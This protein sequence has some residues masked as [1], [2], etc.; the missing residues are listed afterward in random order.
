MRGRF[1]WLA[2]VTALLAQSAVAT[3]CERPAW[4]QWQRFSATAIQAD[5]RVLESS[6][7]ANHSTS[8][9]Q[10]YA[11]FFAL[12]ANEPATFERIWQWSKNNLAQGDLGQHLPAWLWGQGPDGRWAVQDANAASDADLWFAYSLLEAARLWQRPN[13]AADAR[14]LLARVR[15]DEVVELPGLGPTLLPGPKGFVLPEHLWRLNLSYLPPF[16]L[17]RL[18]LEE[19]K[20]PWTALLRQLPTLLQGAGPHQLAPDWTGY[21]GTAP[22]RG[23]V[24]DD[25]LGPTQGS[26]DAIRVY[27]W[28]GLTDAADPLSK[29]LLAALEGMTQATADLGVPPEKVDVRSGA[30]AGQGPVGFSAALVPFL[31]QQGHT[32]LADAQQRRAEAGLGADQPLHYYDQMLGLF[33]LGWGAGHYRFAAD[34]RLQPSWKTPCTS[35]SP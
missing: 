31:R 4:P 8:E 13:Y 26:Y 33:G 18:A 29:P 9:G 5:G 19:P 28:A 20:G 23:L 25:P 6:L 24:V 21:R 22:A 15:A 3:T 27:L 16:L 17:R 2:L 35:T 7:K 14:A 10:S 12:V 34:G 1:A 30:T 32:W 11:L